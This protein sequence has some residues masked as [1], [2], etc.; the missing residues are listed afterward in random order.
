MGIGFVLVMDPAH[1]ADAGAL[2][3]GARE[4]V[5]EIGEVVS[6]HGVVRYA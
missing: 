5:T 2:L 6:G 1:A 3:R 4:T